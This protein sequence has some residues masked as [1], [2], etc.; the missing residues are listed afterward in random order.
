MIYEA[1]TFISGELNEY[2]KAK[3]G[4][5]DDKLMVSNLVNQ[6]GSS[7]IKEENKV[8][9]TLVGVEEEKIISKNSYFNNGGMGK[10]NP[11]V[12]INLFLLFSTSFSGTLI[13]E[14]FKFVSVIIGFFQGTNVFTPTN[15]P[16]LDPAI[17]KLVFELYNLS[18]HE[19]N[20]LWAS[21]G[22]KYTPSVLYKMRMLVID[23]QFVKTPLA[24]ITGIA[25]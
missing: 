24:P 21:L 3:F 15:A 22:A 7:A 19:Q 20:N 5:N 13:S 25:E 18:F 11:P 12:P 4:L 16:D 6:D 1:I 2:I 8:I 9:L 23:E 10:S 17:G 14:A